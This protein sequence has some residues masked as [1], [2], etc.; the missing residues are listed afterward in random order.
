MSARAVKR[1]NSSDI[2]YCN[3]KK[4]NF[5]DIIN[6]KILYPDDMDKSDTLSAE[7]SA[8]T[9]LDCPIIAR[10][11]KKTPLKVESTSDTVFCSDV[12][13]YNKD[14]VKFARNLVDVILKHANSCQTEMVY[15][16]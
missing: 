1:E 3:K 15:F 4:V 9:E 6:V 14:A 2:V 11:I 5:S 12:S 10:D 16:P 7:Q 8:L 13:T